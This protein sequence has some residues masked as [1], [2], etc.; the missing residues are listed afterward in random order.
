MLL[1]PPMSSQRQ[2]GNSAQARFSS[3]EPITRHTGNGLGS[4]QSIANKNADNTFRDRSDA[5]R[6]SSQS[7]DT[8][9][10]GNTDLTQDTLIASI[11]ALIPRAETMERLLRA[12]QRS[13]QVKLKTIANQQGEIKQLQKKI[14]LQS[15]EITRLKVLLEAKD[16]QIAK[17]YDEKEKLRDTIRIREEAIGALNARRAL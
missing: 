6:P 3:S 17:S 11:K 7:Q 13:E 2:G 4:S 16:Q 12:N 15:Q 10:P 14:D 8:N 1:T 5:L 9:A